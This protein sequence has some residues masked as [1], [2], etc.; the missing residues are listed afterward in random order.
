MC[1]RIIVKIF[2]Y[3]IKNA[4]L[5]RCARCI[6]LIDKENP[7]I[8]VEVK[9]LDLKIKVKILKGTTILT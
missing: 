6:V 8:R 9:R 4:W 3:N 5:E 1:A 2:A 7:S